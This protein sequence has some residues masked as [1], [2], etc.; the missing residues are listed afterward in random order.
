M[1]AWT[2]AFGQVAKGTLKSSPERLWS[3]AWARTI[4]GSGVGEQPACLGNQSGQG[5]E[6]ERL[7][8]Q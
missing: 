6:P 1:A 5:S 4:G 8:M 7:S 3:S 2:G